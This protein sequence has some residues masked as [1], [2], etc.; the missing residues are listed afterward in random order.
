MQVP[1]STVLF[2]MSPPPRHAIKAPSYVDLPTEWIRLYVRTAV[3]LGFMKP[4][5]PAYYLDLNSIAFGEEGRRWEAGWMYC[6]ADWGALRAASRL[7]HS[8]SLLTACR[9]A[10]PPAADCLPWCSREGL[11]VVDS[12]NTLVWQ[13]ITNTYLQLPQAH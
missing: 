10:A 2:W 5:G 6:C 7:P 13:L 1:P 9:P 3:D 11:H 12:L 8:L 4:S